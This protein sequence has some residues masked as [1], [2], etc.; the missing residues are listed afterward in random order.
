MLTNQYKKVLI[1]QTTSI[2]D[3]KLDDPV[4]EEKWFSVDNQ[5]TLPFWITLGFVLRF[6]Y[7]KSLKI[8]DI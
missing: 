7:F 5:L 6:A 4:F 8:R 2:I 1:G 3:L